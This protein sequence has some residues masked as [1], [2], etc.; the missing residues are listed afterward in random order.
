MTLFTPDC[1]HIAVRI[2]KMKSS[3]AGEGENIDGYGS[4]GRDD[5][6]LHTFQLFGVQNRQRIAASC[7]LRTFFA[8]ASPPSS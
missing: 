5:F 1:Q 4:S 6:I 7:L 3:A 8:N 2:G